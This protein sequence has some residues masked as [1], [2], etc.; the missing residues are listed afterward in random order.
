[1]DRNGFDQKSLH[2]DPGQPLN[3]WTHFK[4]PIRGAPTFRNGIPKVD[5]LVFK[6]VITGFLLHILGRSP[7]KDGSGW[8]LIGSTV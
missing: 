8:F 5:S 6:K 4:P 1:M 2:V 7:I 3:H